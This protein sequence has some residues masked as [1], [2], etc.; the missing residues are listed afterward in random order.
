[1]CWLPIGIIHKALQRSRVVFNTFRFHSLYPKHIEFP[2]HFLVFHPFVHYHH[3]YQHCRDNQ[4][5]LDVCTVGILVMPN[6]DPLHVFNGGKKLSWWCPWGKGWYWC[7]GCYLEVPRTW[8]RE[9]ETRCWWWSLMWF[10]APLMFQFHARARPS[11]PFD[12]VNSS[13]ENN[14]SR[15][16]SNKKSDNFLWKEYPFFSEGQ[17]PSEATHV[18][19]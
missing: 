3:Q 1:M 6:M 2:P 18:L 14:F 15:T 13:R 7:G 9:S 19:S 4:L 16:E 12:S 10:L 17:V 11:S 8:L 5:T